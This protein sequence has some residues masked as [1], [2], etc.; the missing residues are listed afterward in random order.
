MTHEEYTLKLGDTIVA[1][2]QYSKVDVFDENGEHLF[3][4]PLNYG[5]Q[6]PDQLIKMGSPTNRYVFTG[7]YVIEPRRR[8]VVQQHPQKNDVGANPDWRPNQMSPEE[9]RMRS[10]IR[11]VNKQ[12]AALEKH[13]KAAHKLNEDMSVQ[14]EAEE[15]HRKQL[16]EQERAADVAAE[17]TDQ[18]SEHEVEQQEAQAQS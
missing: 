18:G 3:T 5:T 7:A 1:T 13:L 10:L 6:R 8:I 17:E 14:A 11:H 2:E 4:W 16:K 12:N 9:V 15:R